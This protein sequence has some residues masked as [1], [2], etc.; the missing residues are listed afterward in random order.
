M[1]D[2]EQARKVYAAIMPRMQEQARKAMDDSI[3]HGAGFIR[4]TPLS[5]EYVPYADVLEY[6]LHEAAKGEGR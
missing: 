6:A 1:N 4:V 2:M 5:V 3:L